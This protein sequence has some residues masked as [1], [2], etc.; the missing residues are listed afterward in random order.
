MRLIDAD[1]LKER[2][3]LEAMRNK[4]RVSF[5]GLLDCMPT[6]PSADT[7]I[8]ALRKYYK[9][10]IKGKWIDRGEK[11]IIRW[12]CSECGRPDRYIYN[13][14]PDCGA[15]MREDRFAERKEE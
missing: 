7:S 1:L 15:D 9:P 5:S 2:V 14:C 8:E 6:I 13:F 11:I 10:I 4:G 3:E 12:Q